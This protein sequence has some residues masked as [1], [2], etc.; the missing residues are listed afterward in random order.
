MFIVTHIDTALSSVGATY[1]KC[2]KHTASTRLYKIHE[3]QIHFLKLTLWVSRCSIQPT[4]F[5]EL[6]FH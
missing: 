4:P 1:I 3:R 6:T 2:Y 5:F